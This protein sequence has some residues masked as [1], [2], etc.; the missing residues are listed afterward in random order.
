[1]FLDGPDGQPVAGLTWDQTLPGG[2]LLRSVIIP[3]GIGP[4]LIIPFLVAF[5]ARVQNM[6]RE[7]SL[8]ELRLHEE[9]ELNALKG[10]LVS[11]VSHEFRA[12]LALIMATSE[13]LMHYGDWL[14]DDQRR[15]E[16]V[17]ISNDVDRLIGML[18]KVVAL[19]RSDSVLFELNPTPVH[20]GQLCQRIVDKAL[21]TT[22]ENR[23]VIL[24][25]GN[26]IGM[27]EPASLPLL[28]PSSGFW[29][30]WVRDL[31]EALSHPGCC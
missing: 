16:L 24:Q 14:D 31:T 4:L 10:R 9:Q 22:R 12:P 11:M 8:L 23:T 17:S 25:G 19:Q 3:V 13:I 18:G 27:I 26:K 5:V 7:G 15:G 29:A 2:A 30:G 28:Y 6:V 20:I 1:M 21:L